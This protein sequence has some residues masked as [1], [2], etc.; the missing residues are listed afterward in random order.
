MEPGLVTTNLSLMGVEQVRVVE[1]RGGRTGSDA[2]LIHLTPSLIAV[3]DFLIQG[4]K[5][6]FET[7]TNFWILSLMYCLRPAW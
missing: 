3:S 7:A 5:G 2:E 6:I 1:S 4:N